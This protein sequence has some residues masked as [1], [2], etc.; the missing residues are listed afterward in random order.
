MFILKWQCACLTPIHFFL[1]TYANNTC[2]KTSVIGVAR[3]TLNSPFAVHNLFLVPYL[4]G[5]LM[6]AH[7]L[8]TLWVHQVH[9]S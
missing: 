1:L 6:V 4:I 3:T 9:L 8:G 7:S 2:S 5:P